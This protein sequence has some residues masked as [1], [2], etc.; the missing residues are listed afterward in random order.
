M[1]PAKTTPKKAAPSSQG[2]LGEVYF[3]LLRD[4]PRVTLTTQAI[5]IACLASITTE[6]FLHQRFPSPLDFTIQAVVQGLYITPLIGAFVSFLQVP[7]RHPSS[8]NPS[9]TL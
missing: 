1:A 8:D 9:Q 2:G 5:V 4:Y 7:S 3:S 6:H